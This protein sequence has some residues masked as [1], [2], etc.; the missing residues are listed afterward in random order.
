MNK[1]RKY[2]CKALEK[3]DFCPHENCNLTMDNP[4]ERYCA[5]CE[6]FKEKKQNQSKKYKIIIGNPAE[7]PITV[8]ASSNYRSAKALKEKQESRGNMVE[9]SEI[10]DK[11]YQKITKKWEGN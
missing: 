8:L 1:S 4:T 6:F 5:G 2:I 3:L 11:E 7:E 9:I 10:S